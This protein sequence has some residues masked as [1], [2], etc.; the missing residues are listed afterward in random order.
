MTSMERDTKLTSQWNVTT[1]DAKEGVL[2]EYTEFARVQ[3]LDGT[4]SPWQPGLRR[5]F[6]GRIP[7]N[8]LEDG[9]WETAES[10][11]RRLTR[12]P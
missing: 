2:R 3:Y 1:P 4:W 5:L 12:L 8:L 10:P 6:F 11:P 9:S 7:V